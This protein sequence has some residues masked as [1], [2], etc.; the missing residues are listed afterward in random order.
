MIIAERDYDLSDSLVLFFS[1][2]F[3]VIAVRDVGEIKK[4]IGSTRILLIEAN[5]L[6]RSGLCVLRDLK[7]AAPEVT[8]VVMGTAWTKND[9]NEQFVKQYADTVI[10]K[11]FDASRVSRIISQLLRNN[12]PTR[13]TL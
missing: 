11:P 13:S 6:E 7:E 5:I 8:I 12:I 2:N 4:H 1:N 9:K 10:Y 3:N